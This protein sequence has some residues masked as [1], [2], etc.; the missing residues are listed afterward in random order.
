MPGAL[1]AAVHGATQVTL[2]LGTDG[3]SV[4]SGSTTGST[5]SSAPAPA[6]APAQAKSYDA[7]SCIN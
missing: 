7:T 5:G 1:V 6:P 4:T 3:H 2:T